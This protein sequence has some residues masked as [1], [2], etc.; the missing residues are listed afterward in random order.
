MQMNLDSY[1]TLHPYALAYV[2]PR[3]LQNTHT[4][5]IYTT[6]AS[7]TD[8][9]TE[10]AVVEEDIP[11][12]EDGDLAAELIRHLETARLAE[13][14][15]LPILQGYIP[16][17]STFDYHLLNSNT[18]CMTE[19]I[20]LYPE[21]INVRAFANVPGKLKA[22]AIKTETGSKIRIVDERT[23]T[24]E[25]RC[26]VRQGTV[27]TVHVTLS[28]NVA[29]FETR[30]DEKQNKLCIWNTLQ[31]V[32]T[33]LYWTTATVCDSITS[34][35]T[36][37][38]CEDVLFSFKD[39]D[40]WHRI[41]YDTKHANSYVSSWYADLEDF[42]ENGMREVVIHG[43]FVA[44][45]GVSYTKSYSLF[46]LEEWMHDEFLLKIDSTHK[47]DE[48][49][50]FPFEII[51]DQSSVA[52]GPQ[53]TVAAHGDPDGKRLC[54]LRSEHS[55]HRAF[56]EVFSFDT[57]RKLATVPIAHSG[58]GKLVDFMFTGKRIVVL[59]DVGHLLALEFVPEEP[60]A[61]QA[62]PPV[63]VEEPLQEPEAMPLDETL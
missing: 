8:E 30:P 24:A 54:V 52:N 28:G 10:A 13:I 14:N 41:V 55:T 12:E 36:S 20:G 26:L 22:T 61:V 33:T 50:L 2:N 38:H 6:M 42:H 21:K 23:G 58:P 27:S 43:K 32:V 1:I 63:I 29:F 7:Y 3:L 49:V 51:S 18:P 45:V 31:N 35:I 39:D 16:A 17:A 40:V 5:T 44:K 4:R 48:I 46:S 15:V 37:A 25:R 57:G 19:P 62:T 34:Y 53:D 60:P 47:E 9:K 11:E 56:L 59:S